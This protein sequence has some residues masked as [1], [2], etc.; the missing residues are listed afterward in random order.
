LTD[1]IRAATWQPLYLT[2]GLAVALMVL[3]AT[4]D[5]W[6]EAAAR[7]LLPWALGV[8]LLFSVATQLLG[9]AFLLFIIYEG[10]AT[11]TALAIYARL[12]ATRN[13]PGASSI[14][15]GLGLT[16]VAAAVQPTRLSVRFLVPF[17]HNGLF[18]L[19]QIVGV[20]A[21]AVGARRSLG[22]PHTMP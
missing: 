10:A 21:L 7:R 22:A 5:R 9:G 17:D 19:I 14:T 2:L 11:V 20:V 15:V 8:G 4:C 6:G 1:A 3:I 16:L 13:M 12:A 18:H